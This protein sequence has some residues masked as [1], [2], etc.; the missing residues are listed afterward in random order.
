MLHGLLEETA[1]PNAFAMLH[2]YPSTIQC[3]PPNFL[4]P[5]ILALPSSQFHLIVSVQGA[6]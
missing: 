6:T 1:N 3:A 4:A 5:A 2:L